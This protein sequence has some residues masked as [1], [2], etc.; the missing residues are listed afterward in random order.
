MQTPPRTHLRPLQ[1]TQQHRQRRQAGVTLVEAA[2]VTALVA[3]VAGLGAP[4][5]ERARERRH[6]E[7]VAAQLETDLQGARAAA[8]ARN[9]GLRVGFETGTDGSSCYVVHSGGAGDCNCTADGAAACRAGAE[10]WRVA[11]FPAALP[12]RVSASTRSIL[13][14]PAKGTTTP[15]VTARVQARNG[16]AIHKVVNVMGRV[17]TCMPAPALPGY[18]AC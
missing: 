2:V 8:V 18:R 1:Q 14:D 16:A 6:L 15:T 10:A 11:Y 4:G 7:G 9:A 12:V 13:Y 5:F 3:V 17:R